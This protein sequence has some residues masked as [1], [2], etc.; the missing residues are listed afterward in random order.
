MCFGGGRDRGRAHVSRHGRHR[1][2]LGVRSAR[3]PSRPPTRSSHRAADSISTAHR[4]PLPAHWDSAT[5]INTLVGQSLK[6]SWR[7][8]SIS[9]SQLQEASCKVGCGATAA[10][11]RYGLYKRINPGL[12][13]PL[14]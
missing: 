1:T 2:A 10:G 5:K 7:R 4:R 12:A 13:N 14:Q 3:F 6:A 8:Q 9:L 11:P